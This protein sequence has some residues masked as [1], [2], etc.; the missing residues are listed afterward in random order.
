MRRVVP[1]IE[2]LKERGV[3][4]SIDTMKPR[5]PKR[6][7][8]RRDDRQRRAGLQGDPGMA[9]LRRYGAGVIAMHNTGRSG[10][11][12]DR[13][14]S[15]G[16]VPRLFEKDRDR[17]PHRL[18]RT[19]SCLS[20]LRLRKSPAE[21]CA[22]RRFSELTDGL[23]ASCRHVA[24]ILH[25]RVTGREAPERLVG[26]RHNVVAALAGAA[27]IRVHD[28][29][30]HVEAMTMVAAIRAAGNTSSPEAE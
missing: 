17:A 13:R 3:L 28:V 26:T 10:Q 25:R 16:S 20:G 29:A 1:V 21:P 23:S 2:A 11:R 6:L 14:R 5:S 22:P 4:V 9:V 27:I 15:R 18:R 24:K 7:S 8:S 30:E 19:G 12:F